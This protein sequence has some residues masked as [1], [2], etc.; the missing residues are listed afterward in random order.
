MRVY[1]EGKKIRKR[2]REEGL[3]R[4]KERGKKRGNLI[5]KEEKGSR[6]KGKLRK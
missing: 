6:E 5:Q 2:S 3:G 1:E 4:G